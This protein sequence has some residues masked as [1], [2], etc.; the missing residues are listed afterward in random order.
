[1]ADAAGVEVGPVEVC[2]GLLVVPLLSWYNA[3][4]DVEDPRY[5]PLPTT[6][7]KDTPHPHPC[8]F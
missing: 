6:L 4:F 8:T 3:T 1:M 2:P 7:T 5:D